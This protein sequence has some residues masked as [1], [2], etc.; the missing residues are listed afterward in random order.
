[1]RG[2]VAPAATGGPQVACFWVGYHRPLKKNVPF[3]RHALGCD[4]ESGV[5][6]Q[7]KRVLMLCNAELPGATRTRRLTQESAVHCQAGG[8]LRLRAR[9]PLVLCAAAD[10]IGPAPLFTLMGRTA[11]NQQTMRA[12]R[13]WR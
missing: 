5:H 12:A 1:V 11:S 3:C 4:D 10:V 2:H 13:Q 6:Q 7:T 9:L 8:S